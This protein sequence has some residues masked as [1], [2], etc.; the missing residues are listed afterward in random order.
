M[1]LG[2]Y[3]PSVLGM[4]SQSHALSV[5]G[6]NIAN[7]TTGGYKRTDVHFQEARVGYS[8]GPLTVRGRTIGPELGFGHVVG[9]HHDEQVLLIKTA[10]GNRALAFDFRPPSSGRKAP[11]NKWEGLEYRLMVE[12]FADCAL[13]G[14][15]PR[16]PVTEAA[17]NM[18][19][20]EALYASAR[21]NGVPVT[22]G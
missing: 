14:A 5:I 12:H 15:D 3:Q 1:A 13:T 16:Y 22:I 10:M 18:R 7:V 17:L 9:D 21:R 8:G 19:A 6:G 4:E 11:D 2:F 20:I